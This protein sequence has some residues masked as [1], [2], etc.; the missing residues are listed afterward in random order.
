[1]DEQQ[2]RD[3]IKAT[4]EKPFDKVRFISFVK[5][6]LNRIEEETF[7]YRGQYV[8][9]AYKPSIESLERIGKFTDGENK[10]DILV[11]NLKRETSLER[12]RTMQRNF[13]A[14]YLNGSRGGVLKDAALAAFVSPDESDWRFSLIKMDYKFEQT[15]TGRMKVKQEFTPARRWSF[16]V[17]ENE[18]SHTAQSRLVNI[19][20]D[21]EK[22]PNLADLEEAFNIE[23]VTK[24]FFLK[25]RDLFIRTIEALEKLEKSNAK[26]QDDFV[27]KGVNAV[28][29]AK[30]LLGQI[31]FLYFLQKKGWFGVARDADWGTGSKQFLRELFEKKHGGYKN[32]FNDI[33]E[34]LFYEA[35]RIGEE[36]KQDDYYYSR[37]NCKIPFLNGGLFDPIGN[38]DWVHTDI[39]LPDSLF[40]N[41]NRTKEGDIGDGI[42]DIFDRYNFT[43]RE[44]EPLEKEVAI[45]PELLGKAYE[46]FNAIRPDNFEAYKEALKSGKKGDETKFNKQFG[47]YYTPRE[48]V[49][50]MCQQS[51]IN[52]LFTELN[53][54][55]IS[56]EKLDDPHLDMFG[57]KEKKGQLDITIEHTE[58]PEILKEDIETMIHLGEQ[59]SE[60]ESIALIKEQRIN[61][62]IQKS[63][64]TKLQLSESIRNNAL[65]ID[66]K[67]EDITVCDPAVGSGAFPVGMMSEIVKARTVLTTFISAKEN[68][69]SYAFKRRCIEHSLYGVDIDP[70]AVEIAKLRLWLSLVVDE[71]DIKQIKP[72][73]NLDYKIV[74]GNSLLGVEKNLFNEK[75]FGELKKIKPL[76]FNET[77]PT[78][79]QEYKNQIDGF[80]KEITSGHSEFDFEVYFSEVFHEKGG[81]DVVIANPP[82]VSTKGRDETDKKEL[83]KIYGFA[84]D[85]YSHFYFR[86]IEIAS[87]N[88]GVLCFISSKTFWT[89]Q[90]KKNLRDLFLKNK[91]IEL[92]DTADPFDAMVDTGVILVQKRQKCTNYSVV[93]KDGK[94]DLLKPKI[95][96]TEIETY[97]KAPNKVFFIPHALNMA[98]YRKYSTSVKKLMDNWWGKIS[99]SKNIE[100]NKNELEAYR[101]SLKPGDI[102]LLGLITEG[103]QGLAT[104]NNGKYVGVLDGTKSA[105][106]IKQ[107]R[108]NKLL[109]AITSFRIKELKHI[110]TK[111]DAKIFVDCK[112][113]NE[114]RG[115]FDELKNK[116]GRDIFG[117]GYLYR[118]VFKDEI[119]NIDSLTDDE[120]LNGIKG[121][122]TFVPYDKGDKEGNRWYLQTPYYID[123]SREN[124][125][126]L[127]N[128]TR[129]RWQG[130]QFFFR[131][132]FCWTNVL[133]PNARLI[134]SRFK[135]KTV[136]DV[137]SMALHSTKDEL[138][139]SYLVCLL[140]SNLVF[141][142]YRNFINQSVN[143]QINDI[144]QIPIIIPDKN[145]LEQFESVFNQAYQI[146]KSKLEGKISKQKAESQFD[147]IQANVDKL[148]QELYGLTEEAINIVTGGNENA[149]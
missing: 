136:N 115:L 8:P 48:I 142:I 146:Q 70:G 114:I 128:D 55:N 111:E 32:F 50:Y 69:T 121:N 133:N 141:D 119:A 143:V 108:P 34:P 44:D 29:F 62:G 5:N 86:S 85:L 33:L 118:I 83:L 99:T 46:K 149:R 61:A 87:Q 52:Y 35:L 60:N 109:V 30:K 75:P 42:L 103:G 137:G 72:L 80:I 76:H 101:K 130:Y 14:W 113:E 27:A 88:K 129:A 140:N 31:I 41:K 147:K 4:F 102:T 131:E 6:L 59:V 94:L 134:K 22:S 125:K 2:A 78:K 37:F 10:I 71:D 98:V 126:F 65:L 82:Y 138:S 104:A 38:Y 36:R 7:I 79:K 39:F 40:S 18:N 139:I 91:I 47:V 11:I 57:N 58:N 12:A 105:E 110:N 9:D 3:L 120:K 97:L 77:N 45:D 20:A 95:Y 145:Q 106:N 135:N 84:D 96:T 63:S 26:I 25:Y 19:L 144:R 54:G 51:L 28:D 64:K 127:Q 53:S 117:Q 23:T 148:V 107:S 56:Y 13:I 124:V 74:C 67:L 16:L 73:P 93:V 132:G 66:R 116:Y 21:D 17:G 68:R 92:Y 90:T 89:I 1:M 123:W 112:S 15:K 43:V 24:E 100:K 49:H 81:F 122:K